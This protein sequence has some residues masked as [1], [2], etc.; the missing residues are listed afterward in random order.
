MFCRDA[1]DLIKLK[2]SPSTFFYLDPPYVGSDMGHYKGYTQSD[3]D[4]LID[5]LSSIK[6]K[7]LMSSYPN[8][9][10]ESSTQINKWHSRCMDMNRGVSVSTGRKTEVLTMNYK[11]NQISLW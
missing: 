11:Q 10:L 6:G 4:N 5:V 2:D 3:F 7:F 9:S 8:E 1:L